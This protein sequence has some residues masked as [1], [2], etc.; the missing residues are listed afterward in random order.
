[1]KKTLRKIGMFLPAKVV[2]HIDYARSYKKILNLKKPAYY[3]EKIQWIKIY[4]NLERYGKYVDKYEVREFINQKLGEGYFP[5]LLGVYDNAEEIDF[6]K[7]PDK[8]VI[9][10]TNG[11]GG[12]IICKD[13]SNINIE[14]TIKKLSKWKKEKIYKYTKENQYKNV[15]S[16]IICEEYLEDETGSLTDYKLHCF[17]GKVEMVEI[18]R[19]RYT[20]HK[21][22]YYDVDWN[23]YGVICK[24]KKGPDMK[25]PENLNEMIKIAEKL[26]QTFVYVRVDL[27][28]VQGKIYFGEL[29]FT[30]ANGTDPL[31]PLEK[32]L[33]F[34]SL[35]NL[36]SYY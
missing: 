23:E 20:D 31:Y 19:D 5:K 3:G 32:D 21:E 26:S 6:D 25:R 24:V 8:F 16:R 27:Y 17:N 4:G 33:E 15:K 29:T 2:V 18:H 34:G 9:K 10:M 35:I 28:S 14:E 12:N 13:K 11:T 1:M 30:P 36:D 22:N 7:L